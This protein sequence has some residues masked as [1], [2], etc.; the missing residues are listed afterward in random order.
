MKNWIEQHRIAFIIILIDFIIA[1]ILTTILIIKAT[2]SSTLT[3]L[4]APSDATVLVNGK[5][6]KNGTYEFAPGEITATIKKEGFESKT[7]SLNLE[8]N[9]DTRLYDFLIEKSGDFSY[10]RTNQ[11][12]FEILKLVSKNSDEAQKF[13]SS[14]NDELALKD[15]LPITY[16]NNSFDPSN[17]INLSITYNTDECKQK[18]YCLLVYETFSG[19]L[20]LALSLLRQYGYNPSD[21]EIVYKYQCEQGDTKKCYRI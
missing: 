19:H 13:I 4:V 7:L 6:Y 9:S 3:I 17:Y 10:Y 11:A 21:Y 15:F 20:D 1:V 5:E 12:D 14:Y 8:K 16:S 18:P 2:K